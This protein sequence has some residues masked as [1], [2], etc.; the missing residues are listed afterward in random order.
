MSGYRMRAERKPICDRTVSH[1]L[2]HEFDHLDFPLRH[3]CSPGSSEKDGLREVT[4]WACSDCDALQHPAA[5]A[6]A[7]LCECFDRRNP[8]RAWDV[9]IVGV[10]SCDLGGRGRTPSPESQFEERLTANA[11]AKQPKDSLG[12]NRFSH[13]DGSPPTGDCE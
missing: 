13:E 9:D 2:A 8:R 1:A 6:C 3:P 5:V 7:D 10:S 11:M 4:D 12:Q